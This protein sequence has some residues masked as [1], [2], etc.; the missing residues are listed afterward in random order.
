MKTGMLPI[1]MRRMTTARHVEL[2][3]KPIHSL[4]LDAV[5]MAVVYEHA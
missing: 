5:N 4:A 1:V 2:K 3:V